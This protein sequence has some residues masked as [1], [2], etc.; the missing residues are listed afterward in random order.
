MSQIAPRV[1]YAL[2]RAGESWP[3]ATLAGLARD[4]G[5]DL[6]LLRVPGLA[7]PWLMPPADLGAS[8]L[9]L[10][11]HCGLYLTD[12]AGGR[13]VRI[14]LDCDTTS[15]LPGFQSA[16]SPGLLTSPAGLCFGPHGWLFAANGD[17]RVLV[18]TAPEMTL[19][20]AFG[21]FQL[22]AALACHDDAVLVVDTGARRLMRVDA[23]GNPDLAFDAVMVPPHAPADPRAVA[24]GADSTIYVGDAAG[25]GV[26]TFDWTGAV[27]GP[28]LAAGTQPRALAVAGSL[29]FVG[30]SLSGR[31]LLYSIPTGT[32]IGA[33]GGFQ[34]SV[35]ALAA[36]DTLLYIKTGLD[37]QF[38]TAAMASWF[39]STGTLTFGP[40]DAGDES[41]WR[42]AAV[43]C[44][45][46]DQTAVALDYYSDAVPNPAIVAWQAA[47]C[48]DLLLSSSRYLWL[49][50]TLST[51]SPSASPTL[52][53]LEAQ[54]T[55]DSYLDYLP[56]VYT[57][58]PDRSGFSKAVVDTADPSQ[59]EPG[60]LAYLR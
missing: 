41:S 54:T 5:G 21:G 44:S 53:Q 22:P 11:D 24:V 30:D 40:V 57:H 25:G 58:D 13:I 50:V 9:A 43:K 32:L 15:V 26:Q 2:A 34:G 36:T 7:A 14:G 42:R 51:R 20:G 48:L 12:T 39:V 38:V 19:R 52:L 18:F 23:F 59:F 29:L 49:R 60:D 33:V 28:V 1:R 31:L 3:E 17:G 35:T 47:P 8:G 27:A 46:E 56:Y 55:G 16:S 45:V 10:D 4:P 37:D 6:R